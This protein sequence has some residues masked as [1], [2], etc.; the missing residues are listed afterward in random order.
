MKKIMMAVAS[1]A[2]AVVLTGCGG[3]PSSVAVDFANAVIQGET[4][5]AVGYC[6]TSTMTKDAIKKGLKEGRI[7]KTKK[8]IDD[9][10]LE[11]I[12][13]SE[14]IFVP[15]EDAG[16]RI[17]NG[18]KIVNGERASVDVQF[19]KGKDKRSKGMLV[20]LIKVDG[21]WRVVDFSYKAEGNYDTSDK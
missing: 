10:K 15:A 19:V 20:K 12:V 17:V 16:Y 3:S 9:T 4:D 21:D 5:E 2:M 8:D 1:A 14:T 18:E 13:Y 7:E 6:Y 11:A